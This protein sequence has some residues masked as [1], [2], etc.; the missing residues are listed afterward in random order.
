MTH[1]LLDRRTGQ[2][3]RRD[4][5]DLDD[6]RANVARP[7]EL[8]MAFVDALT[9]VLAEWDEYRKGLGQQYEF[10]L[11]GRLVLR[12]LLRCTD[13]KT[14]ICEPSIDT[15]QRIT[16]LARATVV[17]SLKLLFRDGF[18]NWIR[19]TAKTGAAPGEGPAVKQVSNAY[20]FDPGRLNS[21]CRGRLSER[22]RKRGKTFDPDKQPRYPRFEGLVKR[23]KEAIRNEGAYK[24][25]CFRNART[26]AEQA[27]ILYPGDEA[28]QREHLEMLGAASSTGGL[29]P[30]PSRSIQKE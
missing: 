14:G 24:R 30:P 7:I 19:R 21:R 6:P 16:K 1:A 20:W 10:G 2:P 13:F 22:L 15:L 3:V 8:G 27:A 17:R 4:S 28:A 18:I 29:N 9:E 12:A 11:S 26:P 25:A 5:F 23:R